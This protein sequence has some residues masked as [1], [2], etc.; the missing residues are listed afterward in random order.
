MR[1]IRVALLAAMVLGASA[2][3]AAQAGVIALNAFCSIL[4]NG[5]AI[6]GGDVG[7]GVVGDF[8]LEVIDPSSGGALVGS[9]RIV[10][11]G[12]RVFTTPGLVF[13]GG[14]ELS[15]HLRDTTTAALLA[16]TSVICL[17]PS[18]SA[19]CTVLETG[20]A[21]ISGT[22]TDLA[23]EEGN[24]GVFD[25]SLPPGSAQVG[26][27]Y[28][29]RNGDYQLTTFEGYAAVAGRTLIVGLTR[30][31]DFHGVANAT[32]VCVSLIRSV[33]E[34]TNDLVTSGALGQ[35]EANSLLVKIDNATASAVKGNVTAAVRQLEAFKNEIQALFQ[36]GRISQATR[37]AIVAAADRQIA[38]LQAGA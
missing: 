29:V 3:P 34:L 6:I 28:P 1:S 2:A 24:I 21:L 31:V 30:G 25:F 33:T 7:E 35:G 8:Q 19:T 26:F 15:L 4:E 32:T 13:T 38:S 18:I 10:G 16:V 12:F 17:D 27:L 9:T 36:S 5:Q 22:V 11:N 23:P 37:D 14:D 20:R